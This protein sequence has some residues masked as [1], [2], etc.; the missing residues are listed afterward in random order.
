MTSPVGGVRDKNAAF[1]DLAASIVRTQGAV[2]EQAPLQPTN[3]EPAAGA[4]SRVTCEAPL[5]TAAH[6]APQ[7]MPAGVLTIVPFPAFAVVRDAFV[8]AQTG[9]DGIETFAPIPERN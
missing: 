8:V 3:V 5:N 7:S 1:T 2:P 6:V 4:A 9:A